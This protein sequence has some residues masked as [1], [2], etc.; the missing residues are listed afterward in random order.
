[1]KHGVDEGD[2]HVENGDRRF[3]LVSLHII[4]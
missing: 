4:C 2:A 3:Q 1:V